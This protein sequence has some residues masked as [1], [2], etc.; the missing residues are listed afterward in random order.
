[1]KYTILV[2]ETRAVDVEYTVEADSQQEAE[3]RAVE[4]DTVDEYTVRDNGVINRVLV[5]N[6][7][8]TDLAST[9]KWIVDQLSSVADSVV[10]SSGSPR[11]IFHGAVTGRWSSGPPKDWCRVCSGYHYLIATRIDDRLAV[12]RC[13]ACSLDLNDTQA[14]DLARRDGIECESDY[15]CYLK[16]VFR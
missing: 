11:P 10:A 8:P 4:G 13:D 14:A 5:A 9:E 2:A 15:P 16:G 6:L 1:M 12:E 3:Q 7:L